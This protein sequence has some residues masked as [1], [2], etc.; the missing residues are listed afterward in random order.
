MF[1]DI[2]KIQEYMTMTI[3]LMRNF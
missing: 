1:S 2:L 3:Q